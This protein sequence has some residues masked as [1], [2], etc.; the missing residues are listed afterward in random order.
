M[1]AKAPTITVSSGC[2][3]VELPWG[4]R[5]KKWSVG[6]ACIEHVLNEGLFEPLME[7]PDLP[8]IRAEWRRQLALA[9]NTRPRT[10][11]LSA[12]FHTQ[13][14]VCHHRLRE[15][16]DDDHLL[17]DLAAAWLPRYE[18]AGLE[19]YR[20]ENI[21]RFEAGRMGS[22]WSDKLATAE[23]FARAQNNLGKGGVVLRAA[24]PASA[25]IAGP[26]AHSVRMDE[27]EFTVDTRLL[28]SV[29]ASTRFPPSR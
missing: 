17:L 25:I 12:A 14:H 24:I 19:L 28:R 1:T 20:G 13:W 29:T 3:S 11:E 21:D 5:K 10:D 16:V 4:V 8:T 27:S 15:L 7:S 6:N 18:G 23:L 22:A 26:S 2:G 9:L